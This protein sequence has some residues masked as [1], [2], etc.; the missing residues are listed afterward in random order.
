MQNLNRILLIKIQNVH[1]LEGKNKLT[2]SSLHQKA[3]LTGSA[4]HFYGALDERKN[5]SQISPGREPRQLNP[6]GH[7]CSGRNL[8]LFN[9]TKA[10]TL[11]LIFTFC[12]CTA[13]EDLDLPLK[14]PQWNLGW[15]CSV[16]NNFHRSSQ[17]TPHLPSS[18][19]SKL[20]GVKSAESRIKEV[21]HGCD[22]LLRW[23]RSVIDGIGFHEG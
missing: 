21:V 7:I 5:L 15:S 14:P 19:T 9:S 2:F 18:N 12:C 6:L 13:I 8:G 1:H 17:A 23:V 11:I 22:V 10:P 4:C 20:S 3:S 16:K